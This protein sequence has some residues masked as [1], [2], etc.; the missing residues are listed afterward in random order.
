[1]P[2]APRTLVDVAIGR[3]SITP[4]H[5]AYRW[6]TDA[7]GDGVTM[8]YADLD[9]R[10]R[11][12]G[13]AL[14]R[15]GAGGGRV[16]LGYPP[17]LD[18]IV[19]FIGCLY[20]GATAVP[21]PPLYP[22]RLERARSTLGHIIQDAD[23]SAVL[24]IRSLVGAFEEFDAKLSNWQPVPVIT[25]DDL[26]DG[27]D[28]WTPPAIDEHSLALL[29]YTSGSTSAPR[30]VM[31]THGNLVHNAAAITKAMR[32]GP[33]SVGVVWLPPHH[34]MGL[35]GGIVEPLYAGFTMGLMSPLTLLQRPLRWLQAVSRWRATVTGGPNFA[36]ELAIQRTTPEQRA[37]LRLDS[38]RATFTGAEPIR[39]D[40]L[41]RFAEAFAAAGFRRDSFHPCYGLAESTLMVSGGGRSVPVLFEADAGALEQRR[42]LPAVA[43]DAPSRRRLVGSGRA[44]S[45][46]RVVIADPQTLEQCPDR[47]VGEIWVGGASVARG[48]W[49]QP[50]ETDRTFQARLAGTGE[51]PF[52]RTGDLGFLDN[53]ELFVTGRIK[54]L[55]IID[56]RNLYPH[57]IEATAEQ[58]HPSIR[59]ASSAAFAI[60]DGG[61]ERLVVA[62]E[63]NRE[64]L[65]GADAVDPAEGNQDIVQ[66]IRRAVG[67]VHDVAVHAVVLL[68]P[69]GVPRTTSGKIQRNLCR[70]AFEANEYQPVPAQ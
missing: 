38:L 21:I 49:R 42:A 16:L 35:I 60:D 56:G 32:M 9:R 61:M 36:F 5:A 53:G 66:A 50:E 52:L 17:G 19:G 34:D 48:Y 12:V 54:H 44:I 14:Q 59:A 57:D 26:Q 4:G 18:F 33:D 24:A 62:V 30:G 63:I 1:M 15:T 3:A 7:T 29:Q 64:R 39:A 51:G 11:A 6:L 58:S 27:G 47:E 37:E 46:Q 23:P 28:D 45:G 43:G 2:A 22:G 55:I 20:A 41:D 67:E 65:R 68:P 10:A 25:T 70:Q 8:T 69:G 31:V 13:A 40:T